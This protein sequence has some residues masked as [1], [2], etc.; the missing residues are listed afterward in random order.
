MKNKTC[1]CDLLCSIFCYVFQMSGYIEICVLSDLFVVFVWLRS[2]QKMK[3]KIPKQNNNNITINSINET[4]KTNNNHNNVIIY[5]SFILSTG[6][7]IQ[8]P[9]G[10]ISFSCFVFVASMSFGVTMTNGTIPKGIHKC[11]EGFMKAQGALDKWPAAPRDTRN[12]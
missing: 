5:R 10:K 2:V 4:S 6:R 12:K 7:K 11:C 3:M 9:C 8:A 1:L